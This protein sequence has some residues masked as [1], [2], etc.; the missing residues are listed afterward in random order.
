MKA[1]SRSNAC[2][3]TL[4]LIKLHLRQT[5]QDQDT[6]TIISCQLVFLMDPVGFT[7]HSDFQSHSTAPVSVD[8]A[9]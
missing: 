5:V 4:Q 7:F 6:F 3:R 2:L 9:V 1:N 8:G